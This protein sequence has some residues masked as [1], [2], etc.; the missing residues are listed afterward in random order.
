MR[1]VMIG[2][3]RPC[4]VELERDAESGKER[5]ILHF[6]HAA[7]LPF[8]ARPEPEASILREGVAVRNSLYA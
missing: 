2:D 3:C 7:R 1:W 8:E 4:R 5:C 6:G